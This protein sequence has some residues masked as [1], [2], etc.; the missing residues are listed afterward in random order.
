MKWL[1][2]FRLVICFWL[3]NTANGYLY[4]SST[5]LVILDVIFAVFRSVVISIPPFGSAAKDVKLTVISEAECPPVL[6]SVVPMLTPSPSVVETSS[7]GLSSSS[8]EKP[9]LKQK[10]PKDDKVTLQSSAVNKEIKGVVRKVVASS[11]VTCS[12]DNF[13]PTSLQVKVCI[14]ILKVVNHIVG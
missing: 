1:I 9:S 7:D 13:K 5:C 4:S 2:W 6:K 12:E 14:L 11:V 10:N 8:C 3:L